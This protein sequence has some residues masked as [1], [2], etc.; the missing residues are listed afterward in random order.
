MLIHLS[1][2]ASTIVATTATWLFYNILNGV[3]L[4]YY[5]I[6]IRW[7]LISQK[8]LLIPK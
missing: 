6:D 4:E 3:W 5:I 2:I 7:V 1:S 8:R